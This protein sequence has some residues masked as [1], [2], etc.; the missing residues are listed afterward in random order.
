MK[1]RR[2]EYFIF[3]AV[4]PNNFTIAQTTPSFLV[5]PFDLEIVVFDVHQSV[6]LAALHRDDVLVAFVLAIALGDQVGGV[7]IHAPVGA[8]S[9]ARLF[10]QQTRTPTFGIDFSHFKMTGVT[11]WC[12]AKY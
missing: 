8:G 7:A 4:H 2:Q 3:K 5:I 1:E 12:T 11:I 9:R 6:L 10:S